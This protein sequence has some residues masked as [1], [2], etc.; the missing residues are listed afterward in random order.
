MIPR[1]FSYA[2]LLAL[3]MCRLIVLTVGCI[4]YCWWGIHDVLWTCRKMRKCPDYIHFSVSFPLHISISLYMYIHLNTI[5]SGGVTVIASG[6]MQ[7]KCLNF[8]KI[9]LC[10]GIP[11]WIWESQGTKSPFCLLIIGMTLAQNL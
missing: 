5:R 11:K 9:E 3:S 7:Q 4:T 10:H 8:T 1:H 2:F 6:L